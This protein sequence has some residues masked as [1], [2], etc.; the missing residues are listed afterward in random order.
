MRP[1]RDRSASLYYWASFQLFWALFSDN[2]SIDHHL[3]P[4]IS[5]V[6]HN[7]LSEKKKCLDNAHCGDLAVHVADPTANRT[8]SRALLCFA[9]FHFQSSGLVQPPESGSSPPS[10]HLRRA[11]AAATKATPPALARADPGGPRGGGPRRARPARDRPLRRRRLG[12]QP[13]QLH[14][15]VRCPPRARG[16]R[17]PAPGGRAGADPPP[18]PAAT[19]AP[20]RGR[21][22]STPPSTHS[23]TTPGGSGSTSALW[24]GTGRSGC[25]SRRRGRS[26]SSTPPTSNPTSSGSAALLSSAPPGAW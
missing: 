7:R 12:A 5:F 14:R 17:P 6:R 3:G 13:H 26:W 19:L 15:R 25:A 22:W 16:L 11:N 2:Q 20:P 24:T 8:L 9:L 4:K 10:P 23:S 21:P 1:K 18:A